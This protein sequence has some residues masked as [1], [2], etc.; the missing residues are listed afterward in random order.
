VPPATSATPIS[1][2]TV[3]PAPWVPY[4]RA[5]CNVGEVA[6]ANQELENANY[7]I[8]K[9][10]GE[11]SPEEQQVLNDTEDSYYLDP[12]VADYIGL[13]IHCARGSALCANA[14]AVKYGQTTPS[15]TAVPD[16]LPAEPGGYNGYQALFGYK[17]I[18]PELGEGTANLAHDGVPVTDSAGYLTDLFGNEI[19]DPYGNEGNGPA[20]GFPGYGSINAAQSLAF[21]ADML[22]NN[23][24]VVNIYMADLHGNEDIPGLTACADAPDALGSQCYLD[25][26]A[27]YNQAFGVFSQ[28]LAAGGITPKN[29][30][31]V[32]SS[33]EGDHEA[34]ANVGRAI[35]PTPANCDGATVSGSTVPDDVPCT[36]RVRHR[37]G[38]LPDRG[39]GSGY[40]HGAQLRARPGRADS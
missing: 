6:T 35:Q 15:H 38:V 37:T 40:E 34:G 32:I 33:D 12:E 2:T 3:T 11:N 9:V 8:G 20:P 18:A 4:T 7:D 26:A 13:G 28:R 14:E 39:P 23:V 17:Y 1:P 30:L 16:L 21:A 19:D 36:Y 22:E 29:T 25:Q 31:F 27:Y 5:G 24:Q 10:F